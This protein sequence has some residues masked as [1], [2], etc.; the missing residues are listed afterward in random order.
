MKVVITRNIDE[1]NANFHETALLFGHS[2]A[3]ILVN[4]FVKV[5][6]IRLYV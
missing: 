3:V 5:D 2:N 1:K 6:F 4:K